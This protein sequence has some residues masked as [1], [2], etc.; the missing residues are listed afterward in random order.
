MPQASSSP[1]ARHILKECLAGRIHPALGLVRLLDEAGSVEAV[2]DLIGAAYATGNPVVGE[3]EQLLFDHREACERISWMLLHHPAPAPPADTPAAGV[4]EVR[5]FFDRAVRENEAASVAA[6]CLGNPALLDEA[7]AEVVELLERWGLLA[8]DRTAL[9]IGCGIG[10]LPAA[11]SSLLDEVHGIDV[12]A[13]MIAAARRRCAGLGNVHLAECSG[14]DLAG[15]PDARFDLVL[16]VD[17]LPYI[18]QGGL[19]LV[20]AHFREAARVLRPGGDFAIL[21]YSYRS[22]LQS[23]CEEVEELCERYGLVAEVAGLQPF[24]FWDGI[25]FLCRRLPGVR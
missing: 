1:I 20:E 24:S 8:P 3:L 23:D 25:A 17:S 7:T 14:L 21:N 10:R 11:L 15:F 6:Y 18:H 2:A 19:G 22:D 16:A 9:E 12:S 13:A 4:E 5:R